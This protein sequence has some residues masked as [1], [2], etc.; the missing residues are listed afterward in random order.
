MLG[1]NA[2]RLGWVKAHSGVEGNERA[3]LMA[4]KGTEQVGR[5]VTEGGLKQWWKKRRK[6]NGKWRVPVKEE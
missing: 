1:P 4:K 3:D 2:V 6:R 5:Q